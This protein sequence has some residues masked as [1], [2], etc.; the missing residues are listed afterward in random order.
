MIRGFF[1]GFRTAF[2]VGSNIA[3]DAR[4]PSS[5][6]HLPHVRIVEEGGQRISL[7]C[8]DARSGSWPCEPKPGGCYRPPRH[9]PQPGR[10][11]ASRS[12]CEA[13]ASSTDPQ[14]HQ[15][16][17]PAPHSGEPIS[18]CDPLSGSERDKSATGSAYG[19]DAS[20]ERIPHVR[21][22]LP[23]PALAPTSC[24]NA[25][26]AAYAQPPRKSSGLG[27]KFCRVLAEVAKR[28]LRPLRARAAMRPPA[29]LVG[30][31]Q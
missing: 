24:I 3:F 16:D 9:T 30:L 21:R 20:V 1:F 28:V 12:P 7:P 29:P 2:R 5:I 6:N 4:G 23:P 31:W 25:A 13:S 18:G 27:L 19:I 22:Q 11:P 10:P 26:S 14:I 15:P 8:V 17:Y